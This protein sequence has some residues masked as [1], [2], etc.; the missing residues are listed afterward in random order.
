MAKT[1]YFNVR[2]TPADLAKLRQ[3][4]ATAEQNP[5]DVVR[6]LIRS[7]SEIVPA[8]ATFEQHNAAGLRQEQRRGAGA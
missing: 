5:A 2:L 7:A 8:S 6:T 4:A 3:L 1:E